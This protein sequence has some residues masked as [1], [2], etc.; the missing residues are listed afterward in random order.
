M[1]RSRLVT[2]VAATAAALLLLTAG[3]AHAARLAGPQSP[4]TSAAADEGTASAVPGRAASLA[5]DLTAPVTTDDAPTGWRDVPVSVTLTATDDASGVAATWY[6]VDTGGWTKGTSVLIPAPANHSNDRVHTILYYSVDGAGNVEAQKSCQVRIDTSPPVTSTDEPSPPYGQPDVVTWYRTARTV[7]LF[8]LDRAPDGSDGSGVKRTEYRPLGGTGWT[9]GT[10]ILVPAPQDHSNDGVKTFEYRSVDVLDHVEVT[11]SVSVGIDTEAPVTRD[12]ADL[13]AHDTDVTVRL[14]AADARSGVAT[15]AYRVDAGSWQT[16]TSVR[17]S[18]SLGDGAHVV[19]YYSTDAAGNVE[20]TRS[21]T[22]K[23]DTSAPVTT[24]I[25]SD[26]L[27]HRL[28][29][30]L[31]L[32][33][34]DG[35]AGSGVARTEFRVDGAAWTAG[36]SVTVAAPA[37][38]TNDGVH[39][40]RYRS[41]DALGHVEA[42][43][44]VE[45]KIDTLA[46][47]TSDDAP[48]L[49]R[50]TDVTVTLTANDARSG[51]AQT[52]YRLDRGAWQVGTSVLVPTSLGDGIHVID[53]YSVDVAGN[54]EVARS[55]EVIIDT[56]PLDTTSPVTTA[57]GADDLWHRLPVVLTLSADDGDGSGVART[58][59]RVDE[60]SA[61]IVGQQVTVTAP[62]DHSNDGLHT[63]Y[64]RSVDAAGNVEAAKSLV[65]MIDTTPPST[66]DDAPGQARDADVTVTLTPRDLLSG[67]ASTHYRL[68]GGA[69]RVGASVLVPTSLG[70]GA[71]RVEYYSVDAAGNQETT[72]SCTVTIDT[73]VPVVDTTP[74]VTIVS[75]ADDL[76][77]SEAVVLTLSADDG[78]GTGVDRTEYMI[79][80]AATWTLGT[81]VTVLAPAD[82]SWDGEHSVQFRS[83]D[84]AGNVEVA[85]AVTVRIDTTPPTTIDDAPAEPRPGDVTV[86][87]TA[88]DVHAGV[89]STGYRIDGG[90]WQQGTSV[91]VP[92]ALGDGTHTVDYR[93]TDHAGNREAT[94]SCAVTIDTSP[95]R[96]TIPPVTVADAPEG[97]SRGNVTVYLYASDEGG[98]GVSKTQYRVDGRPDWTEGKLVKVQADPVWHSTD[99]EH[100]IE[101]RS[102][103]KDGN[104]EQAKTCTVR[105]DTRRP[106]TAALAS[107][108]VRRGRFVTLRFKVDD[109]FPNGGTAT[110]TIRIKTRSGRLVKTLRMSTPQPLGVELT[111]RFR[112]TLPKGTYR[113][114]VY[115]RD[116]AGNPQVKPASR[117]LTV[118]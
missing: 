85:N 108:S 51:V 94:R 25:G 16:G 38:H 18:T 88:T 44:S 87:L 77:H 36:T 13:L 99:G 71:H 106:V 112:C 21:C 67:V 116:T 72:R 82:H 15:T 32:V 9:T 46:P 43:R 89:A 105:I 49:P 86:T 57:S 103:D 55:C 53:Y 58:E 100:I 92:A 34:D 48:V 17:V 80:G 96:E 39:T 2:A 76:W 95:P 28:P 70:D 63:V 64:Y 83:R 20:A 69:W 30:T 74:P 24:V 54:V 41:V 4:G 66:T 23:I 7:G 98:S 65:V 11:K 1:G 3:G 33:A 109:E 31:T 42:T 59:Y 62:I 79:D 81:Q 26:G 14:T 22:V 117:R 115:A 35:P 102:I 12:D 101:Y 91:L 50:A 60:N 19:E 110:V 29:V 5:P 107:V 97:W 114:W 93:S 73:T 52:W 47:S 56:R 10:S 45:V 104:V 84:R 40:V 6:K 90:A 61:W 37:D 113:F 68:D 118:K 8:A 27:W 111:K 75:G 78:D